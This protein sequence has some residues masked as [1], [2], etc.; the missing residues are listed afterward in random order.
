MNHEDLRDYYELYAM[1]VAGDP[2]KR[3]IR[4]DLGGS[5]GVCRAE[6]NRARSVA[7]VRGGSAP[8]MAPS[9]RLRGRILS[10]LG[11][12]KKLFGWTLFLAAA[13][14]LAL[15]AVFYFSGRE[16]EFAVIASRL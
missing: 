3:E 8:P 7:A 1:G 10:S 12:E 5:G 16:R 11:F 9:P 13:T 6:M 2:E 4:E 14:A 15:F